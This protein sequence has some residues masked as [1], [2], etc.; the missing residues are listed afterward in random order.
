MFSFPCDEYHRSHNYL[1][2]FGNVSHTEY[3]PDWTKSTEDKG[4]NV[5]KPVIKIASPYSDFTILAIVKQHYLVIPH[6][7]FNQNY[8]RHAKIRISINFRP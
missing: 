3:S 2:S 1:N 7:V 6:T 5:F 8:S 4:K